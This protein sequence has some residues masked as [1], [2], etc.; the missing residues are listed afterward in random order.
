MVHSVDGVDCQTLGTLAFT[1][2]LSGPVGSKC[3]LALSRQGDAEVRAVE[4]T[5][6]ALATTPP[7]AAS[8]ERCDDEGA[9]SKEMPPTDSPALS[10]ERSAAWGGM[11]A[12]MA[13]ILPAMPKLDFEMPHF[14]TWALQG[15]SAM[16]G[17]FE[18]PQV[19][20]RFGT[21]H[22]PLN[23]RPTSPTQTQM[24]HKYLIHTLHATGQEPF[25]HTTGTHHTHAVHIPHTH[26]HTTRTLSHARCV[27]R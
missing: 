27:T 7:A 15:E 25:A 20:S 23:H 22:P 3:W 5:R 14:E 17:D 26:A 9:Q 4:C 16:A 6:M 11:S 21:A 1:E 2:L 12:G 13:G 19:C 8:T 10:T 24:Q 18:M